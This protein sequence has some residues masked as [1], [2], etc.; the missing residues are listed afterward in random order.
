MY[1]AGVDVFLEVGPKKVLTGLI[2]KTL[3]QDYNYK[4]FAVE[5]MKEIKDLKD[6]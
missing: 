5:T 4:I 1:Q 6:I 2:Q 3:P